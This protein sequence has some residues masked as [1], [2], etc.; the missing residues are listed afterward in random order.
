MRQRVLFS[1]CSLSLRKTV[2]TFGLLVRGE[3]PATAQSKH[4]RSRGTW[5]RWNRLKRAESPYLGMQVRKG[6]EDY[7][8]VGPPFT[9]IHAGTTARMSLNSLRFYRESRKTAS[10]RR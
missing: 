9:E 6:A 7:R 1:S 2:R 10:R 3:A 5:A 8:T 4:D